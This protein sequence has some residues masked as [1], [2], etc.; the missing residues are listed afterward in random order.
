M[1]D[2]NINEV[3]HKLDCGLG[4]KDFFKRYLTELSET[5]H[6]RFMTVMD[7]LKETTKPVNIETQEELDKY[8]A[9]LH[10]GVVEEKGL[11]DVSDTTKIANSIGINF[12][13][14]WFN[15]Y[16]FNYVM[17][18][19]RADNYEAMTKFCNEYPAIKQYI[20]DNPKFYAYLAKAWIDDDDA[21]KAK[22]MLYLKHIVNY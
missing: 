10:H 4:V 21:P 12:N 6:D 19:V 22:L 11:W 14:S 13:E 2:L 18:M 3:I 9:K 16:S 5:N 17:N 20:V 8:L 1:H 7:E 15:E